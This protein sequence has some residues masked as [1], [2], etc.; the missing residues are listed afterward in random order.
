M[1][2]RGHELVERSGAEVAFLVDL[3]ERCADGVVGHRHVSVIFGVEH[4]E[5]AVGAVEV[6]FA[7]VA[8]RGAAGAQLQL[9]AFDGLEVEA[10]RHVLG[11]R[12]Q[13]GRA[14]GG[15]G[16]DPSLLDGAQA[17]VAVLESGHE[18]ESGGR[19]AAEACHAEYLGAGHVSGHGGRVGF[20]IAEAGVLERCERQHG[21]FLQDGQ[22]AV[23]LGDGAHHHQAG[24][25]HVG[26][27]SELGLGGRSD[28][29]RGI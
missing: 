22:R 2:A 15:V 28:A 3:G 10:D 27:G 29:V 9:Q 4:A 17:E 6:V 25:A 20:R 19:A 7:Q 26:A 18:P 21:V 8:R 23:A 14:Q 5:E 12:H 16:A 1:Y 24:V 11:A 13:V